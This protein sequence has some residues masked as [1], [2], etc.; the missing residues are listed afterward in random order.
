MSTSW[1]NP[2]KGC[3]SVLL[4]LAAA[5]GCALFT[6][7]PVT[8]IVAEKE[9]RTQP[10]LTPAGVRTTETGRVEEVEQVRRARTYRVRSEDGDWYTVPA[11][12]FR[13]ARV[14]SPIEVCR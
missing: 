5:G 10:R 7:Q 8:V 3:L 14:G 9:E 4:A 11:D 12:A 1:P 13:G 6:C 2:L